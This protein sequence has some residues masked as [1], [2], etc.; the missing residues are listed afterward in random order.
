[1][2]KDA[3]RAADLSPAPGPSQVYTADDAKAYKPSPAIYNGLLEQLG[4]TGHAQDVYLV[5]ACV[6]SP[7]ASCRC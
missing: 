6:A 4:R 3:L 1:M 2:V 7:I 5:S